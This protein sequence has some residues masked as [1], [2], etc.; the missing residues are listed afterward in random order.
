VPQRTLANRT[1]GEDG[2]RQVNGQASQVSVGGVVTSNQDSTDRAVPDAYTVS[3]RGTSVLVHSPPVLDTDDPAVIKPPPVGTPV[4][5]TADLRDPVPTVPVTPPTPPSGCS[6]PAPPLP[7]PPAPPTK[8]LFEVTRT[9]TGAPLQAVEV[10]T[11]VEA[12]C[13]RPAPQPAQVLLSGDDV[14]LGGSDFLLDA[15]LSLNTTL[16]TPGAPFVASVRADALDTAGNPTPPSA[17]TGVFGDRGIKGADDKFTSQGDLKVFAASAT[18][19]ASASVSKA[20]IRFERATTT[21][22][23]KAGKRE[24]RGERR[25]RR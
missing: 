4:T 22:A 6:A 15:D 25:A 23:R 17:L 19:T 21:A 20:S 7:S 16:L 18:A 5:V 14:R 2:K 11:V 3:A 12:V 13:A 1:L 24:R 9:N 10:E 8:E